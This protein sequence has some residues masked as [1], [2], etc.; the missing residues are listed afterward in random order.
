MEA[1]NESGE[2]TEDRPRFSDVDWQ[3]RTS[4]IFQQLL[5]RMR[6]SSHPLLSAGMGAA[7]CRSRPSRR[8][9]LRH[10]PNATTG[11]DRTPSKPRLTRFHH[12][13]FQA[14]CRL[15]RRTARNQQGAQVYQVAPG[16]SHR[17]VVPQRACRERRLAT[18]VGQSNQQKA[19][20]VQTA[21]LLVEKSSCV[22]FTI[23]NSCGE[24]RWRGRKAANGAI[25]Q[26]A[27]V[28]FSTLRWFVQVQ[29]LQRE[30][31]SVEARWARLRAIAAPD[32]HAC[33]SLPDAIFNLSASPSIS[34]LKS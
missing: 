15:R 14:H 1:K 19:A 29:T 30:V 20:S 24:L 7:V 21:F 23:S 25:E 10:P 22:A 6:P 16:C 34:W 11:S 32:T 18:S 9:R 26:R 4:S 27:A 5:R 33:S 2:S 28:S 8:R 31:R 13:I 17:R 3:R 12:G